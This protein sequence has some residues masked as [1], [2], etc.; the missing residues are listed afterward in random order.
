M[1][2]YCFAANQNY[3]TEKPQRE[4]ATPWVEETISC[5]TRSG[6]CAVGS[7]Q[8]SLKHTFLASV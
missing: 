2:L 4:L 7:I 5:L 3:T 1:V 6:H 8:R